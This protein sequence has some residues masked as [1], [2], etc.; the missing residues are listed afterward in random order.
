MALVIALYEGA[1]DAS[2]Q[3]RRCLQSGDA[4]QRSKFITKAFRILTE[5][6][7]SLDHEKGGSISD[8]LKQLYA[9][10]QKRVLA[11]HTGKDEKPLLEVERLLTTMLEAWQVVAAREQEQAR[12]AWDQAASLTA[13]VEQAN[14]DIPYSGYFGETVSC[15]SGAA[16]TF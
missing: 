8:N 15:E 3:A 14:E 9:Y 10:L 7:L 12:A 16:F 5:L 13:G 11:A 1:I 2:Q 4:F 6:M